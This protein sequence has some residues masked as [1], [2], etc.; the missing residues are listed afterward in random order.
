MPDEFIDVPI[1]F[2]ENLLYGQA[3]SR[4][5]ETFPEWSPRPGTLVD[6]VLR[7]CA[8]MAAPGAE[9][10]SNVPSNIFRAFGSLAGQPPLDAVSAEATVTFTAVD[11]KGYTV[12]ALTPVGMTAPG[13]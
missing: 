8:T 2:D 12:P 5:Q 7:T 1:E 4:I 11:N 10:A 6:L 3:V 9:V 13:S